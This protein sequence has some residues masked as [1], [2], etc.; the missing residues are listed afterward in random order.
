MPPKG[1]PL[2]HEQQALVRAWI[3]QGAHWP[4]DVGAQTAEVRKHWAYVKPVRPEP[5]AVNGSGWVRNDID[6][7]VLARLEAEGLEPSPA[8]DRATL[9]RRLSLDL[10]GLPP[11]PPRWSVSPGR[12]PDAYERLVDRLLASPHYGERW[13]RL[14]LDLARYADTDGYERRSPLEL[15]V[16]RLGDRRLQPRPALRPVHHRATRRRPPARRHHRAADRHG[17]PSQHHDQHRGRHRRRGVPHRGGDGPRQHHLQRSGWAPRWPAPSATT[18]STTRSPSASTTRPSRSST[19]PATVARPSIPSSNCRLPSRRSGATR[20][21]RRSSP[22]RPGSTPRRPRSR[23]NRRTGRPRSHRQRRDIAGGWAVLEPAEFFAT[24]GVQLER[25]PDQSLFAHAA[26]VP[27]TSVYEFVVR[28]PFPGL[29][30]FR[31]EALTDERLPHRSSG[32]SRD[33]EFV[34]TDFSVEL[35]SEAAPV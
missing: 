35:R 19:R 23:P 28:S 33:G 17:L 22:C 20:S 9:I 6:R 27:E 1:E 15:A 13:A 2:T 30:A 31:L 5:P 3:D 24:N 8:A 16:P 4:A 12:Q 32:L 10:T 14:W 18:T 29:T 25:Q 34:L 7:F 26:P 11:T 21:G